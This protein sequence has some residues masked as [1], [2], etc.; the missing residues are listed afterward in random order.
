VRRTTL[1]T[2]D[3]VQSGDVIRFSR[4]D[5]VL[6][7]KYHAVTLAVTKVIGK[8]G[9]NWVA[10]GELSTGGTEIVHLCQFSEE[11]PLELLHRPWSDGKTEA[12]MLAALDKAMDEYEVGLC[13]G[14]TGRARIRRALEEYE[15]GKPE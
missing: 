13:P 5:S 10:V 2:P 12:D 7:N 9:W 4:P 11:R 14:E 1:I 3:E 15:L 8:S 6:V